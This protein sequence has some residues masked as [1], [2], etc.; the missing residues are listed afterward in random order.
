MVNWS[1]IVISVVIK[2]LMGMALKGNVHQ[3]TVSGHLVLMML[4]R[5]DAGIGSAEQ[6]T[7]NK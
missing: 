2:I 7:S 3:V 6:S 1:V 4:F 5:A